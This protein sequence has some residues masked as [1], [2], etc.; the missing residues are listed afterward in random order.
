MGQ[1][2]SK[3]YDGDPYIDLMRAL[4]ERELIWWV[5]KA[6]W[7]VEGFTFVDHFRRTYPSILVHKCQYCNGAGT[8]TCP[9]C[10]GF[11]LKQART[12]A[13]QLQLKDLAAA[14]S[15]SRLQPLLSS[16][17]SST[18]WQQPTECQHCGTYCE[19]DDESE[20][21]QKWMD[22][23]SKLA[24]YDRTYGELFN[25]WYE[26]VLH[27]GNLD[28]DTPHE[29]PPPVPDQ[30][31][32]AIAE[33][34]RQKRKY[35][36]LLQALMS[37]FGGH[38]YDEM[39]L[40]PFNVVDPVKRT[41]LENLW[42]M[43]YNR[44]ELPPELHPYNFPELMI[45]P[46]SP[47]TEHDHQVRM[48][49][50][51]CRNLDAALRNEP[52]PYMFDATAGTVPCPSCNG[53]PYSAS[54]IP[55]IDTIFRTEVPTWQRVLGRM[56]S[57]TTQP[58]AAADAASRHYLEYPQQDQ[59]VS[60]LQQELVSKLEGGPTPVDPQVAKRRAIRKGAR[61]SL[62]GGQDKELDPEYV[63]DWGTRGLAVDDC[64]VQDK[65]AMSGPGLHRRPQGGPLVSSTTSSPWSDSSSST[66]VLGPQMAAAMLADFR[67]LKQVQGTAAEADVRQQLQQRYSPAAIK[68]MLELGVAASG[69]S[70]SSVRSSSSRHGSSG[71]GS[72]RAG[73]PA[74]AA[75]LAEVPAGRK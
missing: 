41:P 71:K 2:Q 9:H 28:E 13:G 60:V 5:Q 69:F 61:A 16:S 32:G 67:K 1:F 7:L 18:G 73:R 25:E 47:L 39:D 53:T 40:L 74:E 34:D 33:Y 3:E 54:L 55:N 68:A 29:E 44:N 21:E 56:S 64:G 57:F 63:E 72:S 65:T 70:S 11:K 14:S 6:I 59:A 62:V 35:P 37:R 45:A 27:E 36:Q 24:Y 51:I 12:A 31:T 58:D 4:P 23:E 48:E 38:P 8:V 43:G 46:L 17:S 30:E 42:G 10:G 75:L 50:L 22:W 15:S 66:S 49:A 20:W 19:W 26:D 52:K